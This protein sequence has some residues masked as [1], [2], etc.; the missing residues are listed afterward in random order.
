AKVV[1]SLGFAPDTAATS[2]LRGWYHGTLSTSTYTAVTSPNRLAVS[3]FRVGYAESAAPVLAVSAASIDAQSGSLVVSARH[4]SA[5]GVSYVSTATFAVT[6]AASGK[7]RIDKV[8]M[9]RSTR[10]VSLVA[11]SE[12]T[13]QL[14][15][16][17][18]QAATPA[19]S[20]L[21]GRVR[22]TDAAVQPVS[23][24]DWRGQIRR[25][26][27]A[28][29]AAHI[30]R[31]RAI[32]RK[33]IGKAGR[34]SAIK[35]G[36]YGDS[37]TALQSSTPTFTANGTMRDRALTY[38][39]QYP[40]DS[41]ALVPVYDTGDGAGAVHTRLGWNWSIKAAADELAG[42][43]VV[44]Y[45]NYGIG[46]T[47]SQ[48][49]ANNGLY[50]TRIAVPLAAALDL[51]TIAFGMNERGQTYTYANIVNMI[52]QFRAAGAACI[53]MGCP[54][55]NANQDLTAWRYTNAALEAAAMDAGA[56]YVSTVAIADDLT[57]GGIGVPAQA[58][59]S[60]NTITAGNNHPGIWELN[61]YGRAAV[62]QLGL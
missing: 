43:E 48:S 2:E 9:D 23:V 28:Q 55:P 31:N 42:A 54:R 29:M 40:S 8:V 33:V 45:L 27:E 39:A 12:R 20:I 56:A 57:I 1:S 11:G 26:A 58:L 60:A 25:G 5:A 10:A 17:E 52:G 34:G 47:N 46:A 51:V 59:A 14:D 18:W 16:L 38:L 7:E 6:A 21:L 36:G 35:L 4:R 22:V 41:R 32:L 24:A 44:E 13:A 37:I 15:A 19:N 3:A 30:E 49:T 62:L 61:A 50:P 53:V